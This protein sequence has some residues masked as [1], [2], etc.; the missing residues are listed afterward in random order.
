[1]KIVIVGGG[2]VGT[3]LAEKLSGQG[4]DVA[5]IERDPKRAAELGAELDVSIVEGNGA[6][7]D[8]LRRAGAGE[9]ELVV[10][11]TDSDEANFV[12]GRVAAF[13]FKV[14]HVV[15]RLRDPDL[16]EAFHELSR[17]DA[18][19]VACV[20]PEGAAVEKILSLLEVPGALEL[21]SFL[22]GELL[23][24]GFRIPPDSEFADRP[25]L[26]MRLFFAETPS[27]VAAI[28]R[29]D[30]AMVPHGGERIR[31]GDLVCFALARSDLEA[32]LELIGA[33]E[34]SR[35]R[36]MVA[37][38]SRIGLL[39]A[40]RLEQVDVPVTLLEPDPERARRASDLLSDTLV[41]QGSPTLQS[42]LEEE[43]IDKVG[44]FVAVTDDHEQNLVA[45][46]LAKRL[47]ARRAFALVDNPALA[48]LIGETAL[49]AI[50]SPR[51]LAIGLA[52]QHIPGARV[53][54]VATLLGDRVEVFEAEAPRGAAVCKAPIAELNLPRGV[55]IAA[56][57][58]DGR[59]RVPRGDDRVAPGDTVVAVAATEHT[60]RLQAILRG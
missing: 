26:D 12:T 27:L 14:S 51:L 56:L 10:A 2:R 35:R 57:R 42:L 4:H 44:P 55:L 33:R 5:L 50:I 3:S 34:D 1:M 8:A 24:A 47:G 41:V 17:G 30:R 9:A 16:E 40:R 53:R 11:T 49:D 59:L 18:V 25:V 28:Q 7:A 13:M 36:V 21:W 23:V 37:G 60:R 52:L 15:V 6:T 22:D 20:N 48:N 29:G 38:A 31:Q 54:S 58:R 39:L 46:L 19:D 45:G 32:F 43:E